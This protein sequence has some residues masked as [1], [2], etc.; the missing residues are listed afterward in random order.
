L[1]DVVALTKKV[2]QNN[3][4]F[5][6]DLPQDVLIVFNMSFPDLTNNKKN[7]KEYYKLCLVFHLL[8]R[9]MLRNIQGGQTLPIL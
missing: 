6:L 8:F 1:V 4:Q 9:I 3:K 7:F 2:D 5:L